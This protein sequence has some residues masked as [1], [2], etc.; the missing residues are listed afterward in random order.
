MLQKFGKIRPRI[1]NI[2]AMQK[3]IE[4]ILVRLLKLALSAV[5]LFFVTTAII[6][7]SVRLWLGPELIKF[8]NEPQKLETFLSRFEAVSTIDLTLTDANLSWEK[9]LIPELKI[10]MLTISSKEDKLN[11]AILE[12]LN[13]SLG[14]RSFIK[15]LLGE[16]SFDKVHLGSLKIYLESNWNENLKNVGFTNS[17]RNSE[18]L[19]IFLKNIGRVTVEKTEIIEVYKNE[20]WK[21]NSLLK[22]GSLDLEH[23]DDET[24]LTFKKVESEELFP[25]L[26]NLTL[27]IESF[28]D[29]RFKGMFEEI[30]FSFRGNHFVNDVSFDSKAFL[31]G[32][33]ITGLFSNIS[34]EKVEKKLFYLNNLAGDFVVREGSIKVKIG[35]SESILNAPQFF[36]SGELYFSGIEG[37]IQNSDFSFY[38][39]V[40]WETKK[41][42]FYIENLKFENPDLVLSVNGDISLSKSEAFTKIKG[43]ILFKDPQVIFYYLPNILLH[44]TY[45]LYPFLD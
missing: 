13:V 23:L 21:Q 6:L 37:E 42:I 14:A 26:K 33:V 8:V 34:I 1:N 40:E 9:W 16:I 7:A 36:P 11:I 10:S 19:L 18:I 20:F 28:H 25:I 4:S 27:A 38:R 29:Y 3:N 45:R 35:G 41:P 32:L 44:K 17:D 43:D 15:N 24:S 2:H 12:D 31:N 22:L 39:P 30:N 5:V